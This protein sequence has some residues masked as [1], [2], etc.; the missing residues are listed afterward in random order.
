LQAPLFVSVP[1]PACV[2]TTLSSNYDSFVCELSDGSRCASCSPETSHWI[3]HTPRHQDST[4]YPTRQEV[5]EKQRAMQPSYRHRLFRNSSARPF[6]LASWSFRIQYMSG[7]RRAS[8]PTSPFGKRSCGPII[9]I[10][11][12]MQLLC[13]MRW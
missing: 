2:L 11:P 5:R 7:M 3:D 8:Q 4:D 6:I 10:W 1:K 12:S 9:S 13:C